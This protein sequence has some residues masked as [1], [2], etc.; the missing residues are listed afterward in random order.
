MIVILP[1]SSV[2]NVSVFPSGYSTS[3]VAP[4]TTSPVS[5]SVTMMMRLPVSSVSVVISVVS[6]VPVSPVSPVPVSSVP[7]SSVPVSSVPVSSVPVS[8]VPVSSVPVSSVSF[9][10]LSTIST[11][12]VLPSVTSITVEVPSS[13]F[14][15]LPLNS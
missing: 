13:P 7:V 8:S 11:S 15:V 10:Y 5:S 6:S 1:S 9:S 3:T 14:T 2:T 4:G 12:E